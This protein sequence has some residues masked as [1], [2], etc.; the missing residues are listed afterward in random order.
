V[1]KPSSAPA[2]TAAAVG[3]K[4]VKGQTLPEKIGTATKLTTQNNPGSGIV[5]MGVY[6]STGGKGFVVMLVDNSDAT[7]ARDI[8]AW[9][10]NGDNYC[11]TIPN[12]TTPGGACARLMSDGVLMVIGDDT[13]A[14]L[15]TTVTTVYNGLK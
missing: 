14:N 7:V 8:K 10:K 4:S 2:T 9:P 13:A 5:S 1:A 12:S 15:S 3:A 6:Q 11:G